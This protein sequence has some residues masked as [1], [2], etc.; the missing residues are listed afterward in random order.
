MTALA[1]EL[2]EKLAQL[3]PAKARAL[4]RLVREA[5]ALADDKVDVDTEDLLNL[6]VQPLPLPTRDFERLR[7]A[8]DQRARELPRLRELLR[9]PDRFGHA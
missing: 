4:E 6:R 9:Q 5:I 7:E 1:A 8:L 3:A 2:D